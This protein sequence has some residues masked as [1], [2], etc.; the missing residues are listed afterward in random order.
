MAVVLLADGRVDR[1][2]MLLEMRMV[3]VGICGHW[4]G[5]EGLV[6]LGVARIWG[7][8]DASGNG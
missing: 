7:R 8:S 2:V 6:W 4:S 5:R 3:G 1:D